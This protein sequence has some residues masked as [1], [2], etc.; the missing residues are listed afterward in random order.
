MALKPRPL[1]RSLA[2]VGVVC[3]QSPRTRRVVPQAHPA[4]ILMIVCAL[5]GGVA[6]AGQA[7]GVLHWAGP[8]AFIPA[9]LVLA[10]VA[11]PL[12]AAMR[13]GLRWLG[14]QS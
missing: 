3:W 8:A 1:D 6:A 10:S 14:G 2:N 13:A 5:V 7:L 12:I 4:A 11:A 9:A